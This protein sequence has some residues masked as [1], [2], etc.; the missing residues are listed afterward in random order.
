MKKLKK[1]FKK[2]LKKRKVNRRNLIGINYMSGNQNSNLGTYNQKPNNNQNPQPIM[3]YKSSNF[4]QFNLLALPKVKNNSI[5]N[6]LNNKS[7]NEGDKAK[8]DFVSLDEELSR[9]KETLKIDFSSKNILV[10]VNPTS[11]N[12]KDVKD[13]KIKLKL[14]F[15]V[16][17][18]DKATQNKKIY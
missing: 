11:P 7:E 14:N 12:I 1:I 17:F 4:N 6:K 10:K 5:K 2:N 3:P 15:S 18:V 8:K 13:N 9:N 16:T